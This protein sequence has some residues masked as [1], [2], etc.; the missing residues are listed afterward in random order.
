MIADFIRIA[1]ESIKT[2]KIRGWL[3]LLGI[4]IG[5]AL[6]VTLISVSQGMKDAINE[7]FGALGANTITIEP[8]TGFTSAAPGTTGAT[9]SE[10]DLGIIEDVRGVDRSVGFIFSSAKVEYKD[11]I[12]YTGVSGIPADPD[13]IDLL[14]DFSMEVERGRHLDQGDNLKAVIG[15]DLAEEI[16]IFDKPIEIRDR[17]EI[18]GKTFKVVGVLKKIGNAQDDNSI[19]IPIDTARDLLDKEDEFDVIMAKTELGFEPADVADWVEEELRDD[20][21]QD[22]GEEDFSVSTLEQLVESFN[23][24]LDV[25]QLVLIGIATISL[26]VGGIGIMNTMYTAVLERTQEI[27]IMKAIGAKNS[28]ILTMFTIESSIYGLVGGFIGAVIGSLIAKGIE[29]IAQPFL[30]EGLLQVSI[31]PTLIIGSMMLAML[32]GAIS[33]LAPARQASLLKPIEALRYE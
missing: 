28:S 3:T 32:L 9:L 4:I 2:R 19:I 21:N 1:T 22:P 16:G 24:V 29:A 18:D 6:I 20:R 11:E 23:I 7:Q 27:G 8:G 5:V 12:K 26:I 30:G 25:V 33:G 15:Y 13:S 14:E 31:S 17:V 10:R